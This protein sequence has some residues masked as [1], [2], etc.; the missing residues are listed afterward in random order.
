MP[1]CQGVTVT[2]TS[3]GLAGHPRERVSDGNGVYTIPALPPGI[4]TVRFEL[5]GFAPV[6]HNNA[7]VPLG[8]VAVI[9]AAMQVANLTEV[10]NVTAQTSNALVV[11]TG[12]SNLTAR[13]LNTIP[14]GRTP[15]RIAEFAPGLT[16]NTPN[17][18][19][20]TISGGFA[21]DNVFMIDGVDLNDN[22]FGTRTTSSSRTRSRRRRC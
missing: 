11:P 9:D 13:E 19:Q 18:G 15:A 7:I 5:Q 22:L 4:Y 6:V 10:V 20:V 16:D 1:C 14:V 12:Q 3:P 2:V 21:Y 17:V 8:S